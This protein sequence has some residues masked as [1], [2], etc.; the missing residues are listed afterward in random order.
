M[1][2][3]LHPSRQP[4]QVAHPP[5]VLRVGHRWQQE[6]PKEHRAQIHEHLKKGY[7]QDGQGRPRDYGVRGGC[8]AG[9]QW[10][11]ETGSQEGDWLVVVRYQP[12]DV[13]D[14]VV[15]DI[16]EPCWRSIMGDVK[17]VI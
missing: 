1:R 10:N 15:G 14:V 11:E 4:T 17:L 2:L 16:E 5:T 3:A 8:A 6:G 12:W 7:C 13:V 9:A